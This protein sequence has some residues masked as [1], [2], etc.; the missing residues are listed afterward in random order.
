M[1]LDREDL[2]KTKTITKN[3]LPYTTANGYITFIPNSKTILKVVI[4]YEGKRIKSYFP[5]H[6]LQ[7]LLNHQTGQVTTKRKINKYW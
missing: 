1:T 5:L 3:I 6:E 4:F 2:L 7:A